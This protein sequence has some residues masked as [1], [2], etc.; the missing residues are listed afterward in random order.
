LYDRPIFAIPGNH[1]GSSATRPPKG[2]K[3]PLDPFLRNFCSAKAVH[4]P[5]AGAIARTTMTQP[6]V[7]F[8]VDAPFVSIIGLYTN[9]LEG[10]G[11]IS[12]EGGKY[13]KITDRQLE[14]LTSELK[15][16]SPER[17]GG[18]RAIILATHAPLYSSNG[19]Y[20][21]KGMI[22]DIESCCKAAGIYPDVF[23][24]GH[25]HLYERGTLTLPSGQEIPSLI[26]GTGGYAIEPEK[27]ISALAAGTTIDG[28]TVEVPY[29]RKYGYLTITTDGKTLKINF[30]SPG[31]GEN[32]ELDSVT[33][34]LQTK[35]I[36]KT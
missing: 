9:C 25:V 34:D 28:Y 36:I 16:L 35:K 17:N 7:Y 15:R 22:D 24:A 5:D 33:L 20:G 4:S 18:K 2:E 32:K 1:D 30:Q 8:T 13:P 3:S 11:V 19:A 26:A 14:F 31:G 10:S 6:G 23:L 29:I 12:T 27:K 21:S